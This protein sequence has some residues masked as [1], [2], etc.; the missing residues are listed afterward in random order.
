MI[1]FREKTVAIT[2]GS[3]GIGLVTAEKLLALGARV[4]LFDI[5]AESLAEAQSM[6][7]GEVITV[8]GDVTT[9][10]EMY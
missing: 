1:D 6:L 2:G 7:D 3:G 10:Q 4:I 5:N 9:K 8:Q